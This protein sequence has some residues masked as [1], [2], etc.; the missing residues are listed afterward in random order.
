MADLVVVLLDF[1][2]ARSVVFAP[3]A[4]AAPSTAPLA[5]PEAAPLRT[6]PTAAFTRVN[7]PLAER[8]LPDFLAVFGRVLLVG[9]FVADLEADFF[10]PLA[11]VFFLVVFFVAILILS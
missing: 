5:A 3:A 2:L 4:S 9:F 8:D 11:A 7:I 6:L 10:A 1:S